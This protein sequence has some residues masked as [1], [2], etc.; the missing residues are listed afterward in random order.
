MKTAHIKEALVLAFNPPPIFG[1]GTAGGFEFYIQN[2]G[3]GGAKRL[4]EVAQQ[5][6]AKA[7]QHPQLAGVQTLWRAASPQL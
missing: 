1:L 2:R 5:F 4:Q 6:M 3:E 7:N